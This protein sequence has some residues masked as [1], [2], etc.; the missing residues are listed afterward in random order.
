MSNSATHLKINGILLIYHHP[1]FADANTIMEHVNAFGIYSSFPI[2]KVNTEYGFPS[3]LSKYSFS[4]MIFHYSL[5]GTFPFKLPI[6]F[7]EYITSIK[8]SFKIAFFQDEHQNCQERFSLINLLKIDCIFTLLEPEMYEKTYL[9]YTEVKQIN[10]CFPGYVSKELIRTSKKFFKPDKKRTIDIGY[11]AR[12]L[13]VYMGKGA[14]EKVEIA[15]KI[16]NYLSPS[17]FLWNIDTRE[18]MRKYGKDWYFFLANCRGVIG[19]EAGVSIFDLENEVFNAYNQLIKENEDPSYEN[20]NSYIDLSQYEDKIYY[21]TISPRHFEAAAFHTC[22]IL[23]EGKY[24]GILVP[25]V[26]YIPLKKDFSN[27]YN[28]LDLF[29]DEKIRKKITDRAFEDLIGSN[30]FS[31]EN[32][33]K[34]VDM[35][36]VKNVSPINLMND[37]VGKLS[38]KINFFEKVKKSLWIFNACY[39]VCHKYISAIKIK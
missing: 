28:V 5:F 20:L 2:C 12:Q 9:R 37:S 21:R 31:Y 36:I 26:H 29:N 35:V 4:V 16:V 10:T 18:N 38:K 33:I 39:V 24:S 11:R 30:K 34:E 17:K 22:Q 32:F 25:M 13:P 15:N 19:V 23:F 6:K 3:I 8:S 14:L 1:F 27:I 7:I